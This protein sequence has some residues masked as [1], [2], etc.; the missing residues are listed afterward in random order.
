MATRTSLGR[1]WDELDTGGLMQKRYPP[2]RQGQNDI[3][4]KLMELTNQ[5]SQLTA[6][7]QTLVAMQ[8]DWNKRIERLENQQMRERETALSQG[9]QK[10]QNWIGYVIVAALGFLVSYLAGR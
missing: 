8:A 5:V 9:W 1:R 10:E 4:A 6:Q 2:Q 7:V 3:D